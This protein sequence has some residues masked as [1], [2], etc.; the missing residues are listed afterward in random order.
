MTD[1]KEKLEPIRTRT[2]GRIGGGGMFDRVKLPPERHPIE[3][4]IHGGANAEQTSSTDS[5]SS[6]ISNGNTDLLSITSVSGSTG[7]TGITESSGTT[8]LSGNT[9][10]PG[11]TIKTGTTKRTG[12]TRKS[13]STAR[14][15]NTKRAGGTAVTS[16]VSPERDFQKVPNSISRV[17][18]AERFFKGKSK[19]VW[20]YLWSQ[21][22]GAVVPIRTVRRSRP[23]IKAG[24]GFGSMTTV[25]SAIEN[26]QA[27]GL[28]TVKTI[29]GENGG[30]E[31][32]VF[33]PEEVA[34]G[35]FGLPDLSGTTG[36]IGTTGTT[37]NPVVPVVPESG[38]TGSTLTS[39]ESEG[40]GG[41]KTS[42][43]TKEQKLDDEALAGFA[44]AMKKVVY[45]LT[46]KSL[47]PVEAQRWSELADVLVTEL[48]IAAGRTNVSSVPAFLTEHLR[49]R[50]WKKDKRQVEAE[51]SERR[52]GDAPKVDASQCPDCFGTGMYYPEGFDK[53]V[54]RCRHDN[55]TKVD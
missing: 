46:G 2:P 51:A 40:S 15:G 22:R 3:E 35:V 17:A 28:I 18:M 36:E 1:P 34:I 10:M 42:F 5:D 32:E 4:I 16:P 55:L 29:V 23:Q 31:Y 19:H 20:D 53:G 21:S 8:I 24:A 6:T 14:T 27:V 43:K 49:R 30:N 13:G 45:E 25:D 7:E 54:A 44:S 39:T 11:T 33:T 41:P 47:S 12:I 26:L 50:L 37:Q 52:E 48:K 9:D 38:S